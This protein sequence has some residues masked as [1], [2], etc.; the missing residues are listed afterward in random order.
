LSDKHFPIV[1]LNIVSYNFQRQA[2]QN[3]PFLISELV[4]NSLFIGV[5]AF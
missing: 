4:H 2:V 3:G 1:V 5:A